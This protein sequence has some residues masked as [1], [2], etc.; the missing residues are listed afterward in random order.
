MRLP[1][2]INLPS[3][4]IHRIK[5]LNLLS[6]TNA[7]NH[8]V[9]EYVRILHDALV[10]NTKTGTEIIDDGTTRITKIYTEGLLT[11]VTTAASSGVLISWTEG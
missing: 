9:R 10:A 2:T 5:N 11:S 7:L 8:A 1:K 6:Y 3:P 4:D